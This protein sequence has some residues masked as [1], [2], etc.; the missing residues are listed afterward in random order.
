MIANTEPYA[1]RHVAARG[2]DNKI[3][4]SLAECDVTYHIAGFFH[5]RKPFANFAFLWRFTKVFSAKIYFQAISCRASGR[6]ALGHHKFTKVFCAKI[7]FK[8]FAKVFSR[9]RNPLYGNFGTFDLS[10]NWWLWKRHCGNSLATFSVK[11]QLSNVLPYKR[12]LIGI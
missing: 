6:G 8:Q 2:S 12:Q 9:E 7:L 4:M 11:L 1:R 3:Y 5:G 10:R